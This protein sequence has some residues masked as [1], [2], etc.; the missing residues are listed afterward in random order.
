MWSQTLHS[1]DFGN[2]LVV[3]G[4]KF[5]TKKISTQQSFTYIALPSMTSPQLELLESPED[6][7]CTVSNQRLLSW[8]WAG[9]VGLHA[10][11]RTLLWKERLKLVMDAEEAG[12]LIDVKVLLD[13]LR[14]E[15]SKSP[16][17]EAQITSLRTLAAMCTEPGRTRWKPAICVYYARCLAMVAASVTVRHWLGL[18]IVLMTAQSS[19]TMYQIATF[20]RLPRGSL[21]WDEYFGFRTGNVI[22]FFFS[23][24]MR[25]FYC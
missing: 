9:K 17:Y 18:V 25:S 13:F 15:Y 4:A 21:T 19:W 14:P 20:Q 7:D 11:G 12:S 23:T 5:D 16:N 2:P 10:P 1:R 22:A 8:Y 3:T 24:I 6:C